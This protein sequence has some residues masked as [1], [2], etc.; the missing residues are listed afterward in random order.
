MGAGTG[1]EQQEQWQR[2]EGED[3]FM[4]FSFA[5]QNPEAPNLRAGSVRFAIRRGHPWPADV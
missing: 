3:V 2:W 5:R 1:P 4:V